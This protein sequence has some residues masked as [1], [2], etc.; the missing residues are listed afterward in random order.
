MTRP[1]A[2]TYPLT[3]VAG[4]TPNGGVYP[5]VEISV[6][7]APVAQ[8]SLAE[9]AV[10]PYRCLVELPRGRC[11]LR[12]AF[13][14][15]ANVGGE[16]RNFVLDRLVLGREPWG[17]SGVEALT[18]PPAVAVIRTGKGRIVLDGVRWDTN[19]GNV[20]R[21]R[22]YASTLLGNLGARFAPPRGAVSWVTAAAFEPDG[23][24][25]VYSK[26]ASDFWIN[27]AGAA[28]ATFE[29]VR[30]GRYAVVLLARSNLVAGGYAV[31]AVSV[32]GKPVGE[33]EARSQTNQEFPV[34]TP[35]TLGAGRHT[36]S[37]KFTNDLY[38][39]PEDRNFCLSAVGFEAAE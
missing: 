23:T 32:D 4:G 10:R 25:A 30:P 31:A 8:V 28:A 37:V 29:C 5:L 14:N 38:A 9:G 21:G 39:P 22:R 35:V 6:N 27:S 7:G 33:A 18:L 16:D 34:G 19:A 2:G 15:D 17:M 1:A 13:V 20:V 11:A 12:A 26:N 36:V 3:V 24:I